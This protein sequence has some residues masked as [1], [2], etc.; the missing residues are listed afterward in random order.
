ME[1]HRSRP[2]ERTGTMKHIAITGASGYLGFEMTRLLLNSGN[3][4]LALS[5]KR[6][7]LNASFPHAEMFVHANRCDF[8]ALSSQPIDVLVNCSFPRSEEGK[9]LAS[10]LA[11]TYDLFTAA[12]ENGVKS[13]INISSQSVYSQTR[14]QY[15]DEKEPLNPSSGYALGKYSAELICNAL[16]ADTPH[17][18]IRLASLIGPEF[19]QRFINFFTKKIINGEPITAK[20]SDQIFGFL[21]IRDAADALA[22]MTLHEPTI[23]KD[24]YNLG[25]QCGGYA[26]D[27]IMSAIERTAKQ[28]G[29]QV[30]VTYDAD[31]PWHNSGLDSSRFFSDFAWV[32]SHDLRDS[33]ECIFDHY[34][35]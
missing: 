20:G 7:Q 11:Y 2:H 12:K 9:E 34:E 13:V 31:R 1:S 26:F 22:T 32:P 18:H 27:T 10:G 25:P 29:Y 6:K 21:D 14:E 19:D 15:A 33:I 3:A 30:R 16:L 24:V 17:A 4:V 5:S 23:W 35:E 28:R 8:S